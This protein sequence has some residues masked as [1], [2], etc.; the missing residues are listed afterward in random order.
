VVRI[1]CIDI[2]SDYHLISELD[3]EAKLTTTLEEQLDS[4]KLLLELE[5]VPKGQEDELER[6]LMGY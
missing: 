6:N 2:F 1:D 4:T 3:Y 5:G